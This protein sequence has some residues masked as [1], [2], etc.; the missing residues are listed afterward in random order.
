M[1]PILTSSNRPDNILVMVASLY[2]DDR[3]LGGDGNAT[4][5]SLLFVFVSIILLVLSVSSIGKS[6]S[7]VS[8]AANKRNEEL[9]RGILH[10]Y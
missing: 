6:E 4:S 3:Y 8:A 10:P 1:V 7:E 9:S 5:T 2:P